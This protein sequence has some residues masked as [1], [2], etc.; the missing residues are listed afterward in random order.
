MRAQ[1]SGE[2]HHILPIRQTLMPIFLHNYIKLCILLMRLC[3]P[4]PPPPGGASEADWPDPTEPTILGGV[5]ARDP[6]Q[7]SWGKEGGPMSGWPCSEAKEWLPSVFTTRS[8]PH[9]TSAHTRHPNLLQ[10]IGA[11]MDDE[12]IILTELLPT[13][14]RRLMESTTLSRQQIRSIG[15]DVARAVNYLHLT[16][17]DP[18]IHRDISSANIL[19]EPSGEGTWKATVVMCRNGPRET[20][21]ATN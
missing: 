13:S 20:V 17:P 5:E 18:I 11:T 16:T 15:C 6:L 10:F 4:F 14:L 21:P 8:S 12:P 2:V 1:R 9:T 3:S 19:L 7:R